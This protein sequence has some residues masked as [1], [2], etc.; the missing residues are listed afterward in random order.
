MSSSFRWRVLFVVV[1]ASVAAYA[2]APTFIYFSQPVDVRQDAEQLSKK[3]PDWL[4]QQHVRLGLDLQGGV[5]LVLGVTVE[6]AVE[7]SLGRIGIEAARWS[8]EEGLGL[9]S[10]YVV[11]GSQILRVELE[12]G[13][14]HMSFRQAFREEFPGLVQTQRSGLVLDFAYEDEQ[15][16]RIKQGALQQAERVVRNRVDRWGVTEP[17][18]APRADGS[19]L[20]QLPGFRD[21]QRARELL[22]RTAQLQF[23]IVDDEF[24]GFNHLVNELPETIEADRSN[25][26]LVLISE[27]KDEIIALTEGL[28]PDDRQLVFER[29]E[30]AGGR[31]AQYSSM[32]VHAATEISGDDI[33]DA[34]ITIDGSSLTQTPA[35]GLRFTGPGGRRFADVTGRNVQKRM[36][37]LLDEDVVSAP[38][39]Q[40][41]ISGG[42]AQITLG[43]MRNHEEIRAE[44]QELSLIL[45]SGA[46]PARI[47][48]LEERQVGATLGPELARQGIMATVLGVILVLTF[49][50]VY[51]RRPGI[52]ACIALALNGLFLLALMTGF[53]FALTL[54]GIA[55][56]IL[57]LGMAVDANVLIN[58]RIRQE[59]RS[60]KNAKKAVENGFNK[61]FWTII[62]ANVTTLIAAFVLLETN[63]S[64]PIRGFAVT[65]MLGL[66]VSMFTSLYVTKLLFQLAVSRCTSDQQVRSWLGGRRAEE[67]KI[68]I[69]FDFLKHS[70][71]FATTGVLLI[72]AVV[73]WTASKGVNWSVDFAGGTEIEVAFSEDVAPASIR[74][75]AAQAGVA[76]LVIQ[77]VG[78]SDSRY[79]LRFGSEADGL[80]DQPI[81]GEEALRADAIAYQVRD[82]LRSELAQYHPDILRVDF[83]GPQIGR[84]LQTQGVL[85]LFYAILCV[86]GYILLRF[87]VRFGP[88]A[89]IKM[90]QDVFVIVG[91]YVF[92]GRSVDLTSVAALLTVVGYSV[93]DTIVIYDRI[94]ENLM[95]YPKRNL[96]ENINA[97]LNETL[98]RTINTSA[99]TLIALSG[100]LVF[101]TAQ[102]W[103]FAAAMAVGVIAA[104]LTSMFLASA[105]V[106]WLAD[107]RRYRSN[108]SGS[109][110]STATT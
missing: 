99:T 29:E 15:V 90:A 41:R 5:Q 70:K 45:K 18:I 94:R 105:L 34:Y 92:F 63:T 12:E 33:L 42:T 93:N 110:V 96:R 104:T 66:I 47:E 23:K 109:G 30:L 14:D 38:V 61:V 95:L 84:E 2:V 83:V 3:I 7:H 56:F 107:W 39:I 52:L 62:D 78:G 21:P 67:L 74:S 101:G 97:S 20:V 31:R 79:L 6:D 87:D 75:A 98:S 9:S 40:G 73:G 4:P 46:L 65:L 100:I 85:S 80:P 58:E 88:G 22:G 59:L 76:T 8:D 27:D 44:A 35:V 10:A 48:V 102:I 49:M 32:V 69:G 17:L 106:L 64:G 25:G 86:F 53:G 26:S 51:Y 11:R 103:N 57:T 81:E 37:I 68:D 60:G 72:V 19:I 28:I 89:I 43:G 16:D 36:A 50:L 1:L 82:A 77:S 55:G 24:E 13:T 108:Q 54:P 71:A 91:F